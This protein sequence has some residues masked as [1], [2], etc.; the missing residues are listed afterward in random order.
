[1]KQEFG[2]DTPIDIDHLEVVGNK[3]GWVSGSTHVL[4]K[5]IAEHT[6]TSSR[7]SMVPWYEPLEMWYLPLDETLPEDTEF[8]V[9]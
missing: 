4:P 1:M 2:D 8:Y 3:Q 7:P 9:L 5:T 6:M